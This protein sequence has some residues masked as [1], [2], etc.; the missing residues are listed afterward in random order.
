MNN[1]DCLF[2]NISKGIIKSEK[3]YED[4]FCFAINDIAPSAP[5][6]VLLIPK[7]H[8][9]SLAYATSEKLM[10][11]LML[12][13]A[14]IAKDNPIAKAGYRIVINTGEQ[15]GQTVQHLHIHIISGRPLSWPAG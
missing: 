13:A 1:N 4:E 10:G 9:Q 2:C 12:V 5:M 15:A 8:I 3:V 7:E 11:H 14:K 6:H